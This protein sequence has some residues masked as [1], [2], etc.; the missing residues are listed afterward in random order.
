MT[1]KLSKPILYLITRGATAETTTS[2]SEEFQTILNQVTAAVSARIQLLQ[3]RE[4]RLTARVLFELTAQ[5][6]SIAGGSST[7][8]MINDRADIAAGAGADGVHL[9]AS[10]V[11]PDIIRN[12]F[13]SNF[14]IGASTHS[15]LE[16]RAAYNAGADF[17][18]FGP[19]FATPAKEKY[20][21]PVGTDALAEAARELADFPLL[22]LGGI[23]IENMEDCL[24]AGARG[25]AGITLFDEG[26]RLANLVETIND[27]AKASSK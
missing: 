15:L 21:S 20:G 11:T 1:L 4:K 8:I 16:A 24:S 25:I 12:A 2:E 13:G 26:P 27:L 14:L 10:S 7:R 9:T 6:V 3:I 23:S 17:A 18:V 19:I 5:A 22:A